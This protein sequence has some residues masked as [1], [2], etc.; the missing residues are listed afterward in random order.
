MA[1]DATLSYLRATDELR[2]TSAAIERAYRVAH[3]VSTV[4][5]S[6]SLNELQQPAILLAASGMATGGRVIHHLKAY[7]PDER[8]T[9]LLVGYQAAGTRGEALLRGVE[10]LKIHGDYVP[11]R[12]EVAHIT[13]VKI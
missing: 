4:A 11:V 7:L 2:L 5:E 3:F 8:S 10:R 6:K 13:L 9:V 1:I 12:A